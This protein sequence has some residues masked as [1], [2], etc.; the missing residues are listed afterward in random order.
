ML[1]VPAAAFGTP[2]AQQGDFKVNVASSAIGSIPHEIDLKTTQIPGGQ[3]SEVTGFVI[4]PEDVVQVK[5][6][7]NLLVSTTESLNVENVKLKNLQGQPIDLLPLPNNIW[8][9]RGLIPPPID[10]SILGWLVTGGLIAIF[11]L[12]WRVAVRIEGRLVSLEGRIQKLEENPL[13]IAYKEFQI[14]Q[15][16]KI[17]DPEDTLKRWEA[18]IKDRLQKEGENTR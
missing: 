3:L 11:I 14:L 18:E 9:L 6:G 5:Q 4:D 16:R 10:Q 13:L 15:A 8:S 7:E 17:F 2:T 12:V 1:L